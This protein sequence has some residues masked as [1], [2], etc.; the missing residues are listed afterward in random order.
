MCGD[1]PA[2]YTCTPASYSGSLF[3]PDSP[4]TRDIMVNGSGNTPHFMIGLL[5]ANK[6]ERDGTDRH[7]I[8]IQP[9]TTTTTTFLKPI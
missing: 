1:V 7:Y 9:P 5:V 3:V 4:E 6:T 2:L 8:W